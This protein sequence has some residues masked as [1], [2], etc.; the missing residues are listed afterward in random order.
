LRLRDET[1]AG[2]DDIARAYAVAREVFGFRVIW[3]EIEALDGRVLAATQTAM[4]L[5]AR[6]LLERATR[7]LL[8]NRRRPIDIAAAV[9]RYSAGA[10]VLAEALPRLLGPSEVEAARA[11][12]ARF[13]EVGVS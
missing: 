8:R 13:E 9:A 3:A 12:A 4:L 6:I 7:W 10:A 5:R 11:R 2:A 1:G